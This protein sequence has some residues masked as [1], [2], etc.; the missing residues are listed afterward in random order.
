MFVALVTCPVCLQTPPETSQG[1]IF[2]DTKRKN[3][4]G[5]LFVSLELN[6]EG[7]GEGD[8]GRGKNDKKR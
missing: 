7:W 8:E 4:P 1:S 2:S 3:S 5:F 6:S